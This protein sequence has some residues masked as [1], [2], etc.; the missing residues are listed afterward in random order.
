MASSFSNNANFLA[1]HTRYVKQNQL[2]C[3]THMLCGTSDPVSESII[4]WH[5]HF[6][7]K[8]TF[9]QTYTL[10]GMSDPVSKSIITWH[11]HFQTKPT[12]L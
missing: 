9:L 6:Q 2:S 4:T 5:H 7:T 8:P 10:C 3:K 1:R 11:H 12:F